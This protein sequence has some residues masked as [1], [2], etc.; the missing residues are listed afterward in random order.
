M[1]NLDADISDKSHTWTDV[2]RELDQWDAVETFAARHTQ[3]LD[4]RSGFRR[5]CS[6][7][8]GHLLAND[9]GGFQIIHHVH[10]DGADE[11][12]DDDEGDIW[13]LMGAGGTAATVVLSSTGTYDK[14]T[15]VNY[16]WSTMVHWTE[17]KDVAMT[18]P[19]APKLLGKAKGKAKSKSGA[20]G[21]KSKKGKPKDYDADLFSSSEDEDE[22]DPDEG[23]GEEIALPNVL[24]LPGFLVSALMDAYTTDAGLLC[25]AAIDAIKTRATDAG[26]DPVASTVALKAAYVPIWLWNHATERAK[27]P[28]GRAKGV[29]T[30][31]AVSQRADEW[32]CELHKRHLHMTGSGAAA[33][34]SPSVPAPRGVDA[35]GADVWTNLANALA[36]QAASRGP[37]PTGAKRGFEAFPITTQQMIL[38]ASE[39]DETGSA[40]SAPVD[41]YKEIL[42]LT[43]AAYVA[44]H[45]HHHLKTRLGLDVLLP[46]G[47]CSAV[48]M[49]SFISTTND[50]PE[51]FSLFS[52]GPQ[53]LDKKA[54]TGST[55]EVESADDL[56]RMQLKVADST[57][58]LSDKDIK[59]LTLVRHVAPRDFRALAELFANM[60]GVT[61]LIFGTAAPVTTM[62]GSWVHFLTRT[63]GA[64]VANLR[65]LA[66]QDVTAPSR[67]GW[68]VERRIQ[69]Y[70]TSC[71]SCGHIDAV[72]LTLFD[73]QAERQ[74]LEDGM[75]LHPLCSYLKTKLGLTDASSVTRT[76][77]GT[78]RGGSS[79]PTNA[80]RNPS[81]R[82]FKITSRDVWQV[83]LDHAKDAPV[84]NLCCRYHLNG[85]CNE[86]CFFRASHVTLSGD[87]AA[88]LGKWVESC[89]ARMPRQPAD[90]AKKPKLVGN[91]DIAYTDFP[92]A[93]PRTPSH[94]PAV[95]RVHN[96][97]LDRSAAARLHAAT[98]SPISPLLSPAP[99]ASATAVTISLAKQPASLDAP[100]I[101][102]SLPPGPQARPVTSPTPQRIRKTPS[103][104]S[105]GSHVTSPPSLNSTLTVA[106]PQTDDTTPT[107]PQ[108]L[109]TPRKSFIPLP[110]LLC[111]SAFPLLPATVLPNV[112]HAILAAPPPRTH[113]TEFFFEWTP[114]A[115]THNLA[116]L[117]RYGVDLRTALAAQLFSTLSPGSEFRPARLLAP[118]L[119]RHPLWAV[120]AERITA[121][122]EFPLVDIPDAARLEDVTATLARGN[123]KSSRGHE[124][125]LLEMLKDEMKRGWQLPLP[126][127][128]ALE[129]PHCE[130]AP[131]GMVVQATIGA[132][133]T[134]ETKLRLTHDQSFN[135]T[136][137]M[138]RSVNDRVVAE[139][140]TPA[141]FGRALLRFLHYACKLRRQFPNE[142]LLITKVDCK[143]AY[144]RVHL[145]AKTAVKSST[146]T[147]GMLL[148]ALRMTFGGAPNPSQWSDISEVIVDLANDLVRR[149]DWDPS[150]WSAP[151]QG[152]LQTNEALDN[153]E[154]YVRPDEEF[155]KAFAMSVVDPVS[156]GQA[157]F[158]CYLDDLFGVFRARAASGWAAGGR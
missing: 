10:Q 130:V 150:A 100:A 152:I 40:R 114:A 121:G 43:N 85:V 36:L 2:F 124:T 80:V 22:F 157:K 54:S 12:D 113:T 74:Q 126:K 30:S 1:S 42:G 96:N 82:L 65:R 7:K 25:L 134:K 59:K 107:P 137:G 26:V 70:L 103:A 149:R 119:S 33:Q 132:N 27:V 122:A 145:K 123:H 156:D 146:C 154:G 89:R 32:A 21:K 55:D 104:R 37:A 77:G 68:F 61:E 125:K 79:Y 139:R 91:S 72:N 67:L 13:A 52:C 57:T 78:G 158:D 147:A 60:A 120:F 112:L 48:R 16:E 66:F 58:G 46:P 84:P 63:G 92:F 95:G 116:V 97:L 117:R 51:A 76:V 133:G 11:I 111:G 129:L 71:A 155:G 135:A 23:V 90:A 115:A 9:S 109:P 108:T 50:R 4:T 110:R 41:T 94:E 75:F 102:R 99:F 53:P 3:A 19:Q 151:R 138:R 45:L 142:R 86:S 47:F 44:Q 24:P 144:R 143:S 31:I 140:L 6:P 136:R 29:G 81:G 118:L 69:Q 127:E 98:R 105:A 17:I 62:L 5:F 18:H 39:R 34:T 28:P 14:Q 35:V 15:G 20:K 83:F 101:A 88:A 64:T 73:F 131:L 148:V 141:R 128:A 153:D 56:M 8:I 87:Q 106:P 93:H 38:F 49:A